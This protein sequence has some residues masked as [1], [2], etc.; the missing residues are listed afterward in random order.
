MPTQP[1]FV[2]NNHHVASCGE[3]P[4]INGS[5]AGKYVGYFANEY[6]EQWIF[7]Y[8]RETKRAT[9]RGGDNGWENEIEVRPK[10]TRVNLGRG[11]QL[12]LA[13]CWCAVTGEVELDWH[14][15]YQKALQRLIKQFRREG[16]P[17]AEWEQKFRDAGY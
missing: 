5:Q 13:A 3:P 4:S 1:L 10:D 12:W 6:G 11:E 16:V 8:D 17:A 14:S 15:D 2:V 9:L 7:T